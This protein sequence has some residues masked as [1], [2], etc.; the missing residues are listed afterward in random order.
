MPDNAARTMRQRRAGI[1]RALLLLIRT[2]NAARFD[3]VK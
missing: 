2:Y 3:N 1:V